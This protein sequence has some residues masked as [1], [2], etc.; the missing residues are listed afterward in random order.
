MVQD[1]PH[2]DAQLSPEWVGSGMRC[3]ADTSVCYPTLANLPQMTGISQD[4]CCA[5]LKSWW[6]SGLDF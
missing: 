6:D 4:L 3:Q 5:T 2:T 1:I